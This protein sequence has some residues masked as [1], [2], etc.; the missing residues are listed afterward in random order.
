M[1][2][3]SLSVFVLLLGMMTFA[4]DGVD[5]MAEKVEKSRSAS[6]YV[7]PTTDV[8]APKPDVSRSACCL[9]FDNYT[10][11]ILHVWVDGSYK[12]SV[13][14]WRDAGVCV[15][16][17]PTTWYVRTAGETYSWSGSG[18]CRSYYNLKID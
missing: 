12:G 11:Y 14:P 3:L 6:D 7:L 17:G 18:D 9:N 16:P 15:A 2:K 13:G 4:Q 8:E 1:K 10:G 5:V